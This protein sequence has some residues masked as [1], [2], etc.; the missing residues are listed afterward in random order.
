MHSLERYFNFGD[1]AFDKQKEFESTRKLCANCLRVITLLDDV[2]WQSRAFSVVADN[3]II[4]SFIYC[5][6]HPKVS[7]DLLVGTPKSLP[8]GGLQNSP[9]GAG[10]EVQC[11]AVTLEDPVLAWK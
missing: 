3:T 8:E 4:H 1:K 11:V 7:K 6:L 2:E 5:L 10:Q 9:S